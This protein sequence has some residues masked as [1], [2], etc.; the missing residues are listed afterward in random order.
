MKITSEAQAWEVLDR[1]NGGETVQFGDIKFS[2][3][4]VLTVYVKD[5]DAS[6][7]MEMMEAFVE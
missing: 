6:L 2:G 5:G 4:P 3:W 1:L 7:S